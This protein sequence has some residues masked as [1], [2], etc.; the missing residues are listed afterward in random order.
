MDVAFTLYEGFLIVEYS[1]TDVRAYRSREYYGNN[2]TSYESKGQA[3]VT[4]MIDNA[5]DFGDFSEVDYNVLMRE[6]GRAGPSYGYGVVT[7]KYSLYIMK[8]VRQHIGLGEDDPS[9]DAEINNMTRGSVFQHCLEWEGIIGYT[10]R[11]LSWV[12]DIYG[13]D[14]MA[15]D[16]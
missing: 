2:I 16:K 8:K 1:G 4:L 7:L 11:I 13:V 10:S 14:L 12:G 5:G 9:K 3:F 15:Q 6:L